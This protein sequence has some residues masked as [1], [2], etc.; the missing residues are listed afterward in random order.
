MKNWTLDEIRKYVKENMTVDSF[1]RIVPKKK[2][3]DVV[4]V[5]YVD[6]IKPTLGEKNK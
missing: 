1:G 2:G 5:D 4:I 3:P 6:L